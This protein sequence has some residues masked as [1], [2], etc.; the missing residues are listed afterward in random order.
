MQI[1][2]SQVRVHLRSTVRLRWRH[3][4]AIDPW[5]DHRVK[6]TNAT[7]RAQSLWYFW[8]GRGR[9]KLRAGWQDLR[10]GSCVWLTPGWSYQTTQDP[11]DPLGMNLIQF[12]LIEPDGSVRSCD[13]DQPGEYVKLPSAPMAEQITSR[14]V[15][16]LMGAGLS[17][18]WIVRDGPV[19]QV[20]AALLT[21]LLMDLD[22]AADTAPI[23]AESGLAQHQFYLIKNI[24]DERTVSPESFPSVTQIARQHGFSR[25]HFTRVFQKATGLPPNEFFIR[26]RIDR[27]CNLLRGSPLTISQIAEALGYQN[28]HFFSRQF[29]HR[30]GITPVAFRKS[31]EPSADTHH[32]SE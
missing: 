20:A 12:D 18:A 19:R 13:H 32:V 29:K 27:A 7:L 23:T 8:A 25:G 16:L 22:A 9:M 26:R 31:G 6:S 2:W 28:V 1:D 10:P 11:K 17:E 5:W 14:I 3:G 24:L 4:V 21:A 15:E 30:V